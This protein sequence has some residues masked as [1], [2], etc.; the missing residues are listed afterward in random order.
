MLCLDQ[1]PTIAALKVNQPN[2]GR[3]IAQVESEPTLRMM[4]DYYMC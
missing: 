3:I 2:L 4:G 1:K